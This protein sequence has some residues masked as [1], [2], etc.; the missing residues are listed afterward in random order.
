MNANV[1]VAVLVL[2]L[3]LLL[4]LLMEPAVLVACAGLLLRN[5]TAW[6]GVPPRLAICQ[7]A[8]EA[9]AVVAGAT[10]AAGLLSPLLPEHFCS[11][12]AVVSEQAPQ[13]AAPGTTERKP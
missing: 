6:V 12:A 11:R 2:L 9:V 8:A 4:L 1:S 10:L 7:V 5:Q 3:S 13:V